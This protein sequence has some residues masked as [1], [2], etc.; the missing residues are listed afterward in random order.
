MYINQ[1]L[2]EHSTLNIDLNLI[3]INM[4]NIVITRSS[5]YLSSISDKTFLLYGP[6]CR[7]INNETA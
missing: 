2:L 1:I 5:E 3:K 4:S 7:H 6:I